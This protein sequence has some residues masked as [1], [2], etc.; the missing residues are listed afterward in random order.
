MTYGD[1]KKLIGFELSADR[2]IPADMYPLLVFNGIK[3]VAML[4]EPKKLRGTGM[5]SGTVLR[6]IDE[7]SYIRMPEKPSSDDGMVD[8]DDTLSQAVIYAVCKAVSRDNK[9]GYHQLMNKAINDHLWAIYEAQTCDANDGYEAD[10]ACDVF[11]LEIDG[12]ARYDLTMNQGADY[13]LSLQITD[14]VTAQPM[15]L[16]GA[17]IVFTMM[18][19]DYSTVIV[20]ISEVVSADGSITITEPLAGRM[21]L[22]IDKAMTATFDASS[23]ESAY[24]HPYVYQLDINNKRYMVGRISVISGV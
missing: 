12:I 6:M 4:C 11:P 7:V 20:A 13:E 24:S 21:V 9:A 10:V 18:R 2:S 17:H 14:D 19:D 1:M 15:G 8:I 5:V 3:E 23:F 22:A 16:T